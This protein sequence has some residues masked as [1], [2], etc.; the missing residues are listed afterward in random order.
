M[1]RLFGK[2]ATAEV[3]N[4]GGDALR[5]RNQCDYCHEPYAQRGRFQGW[6]RN[7]CTP[8]CQ[9]GFSRYCHGNKE[10]ITARHDI[11]EST[12]GRRILLPP[13]P[14]ELL[15]RVGSERG[16]SRADWLSACYEQLEEEEMK[17]V[18]RERVVQ[19]V[20]VSQRVAQYKKKL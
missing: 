6:G 8:E 17:I 19:S 20:D 7:F 13:S 1:E 18:W 14:M 11:L 16:A 10:E 9:A 4:V 15:R 2:A 12:H 3:L 5:G